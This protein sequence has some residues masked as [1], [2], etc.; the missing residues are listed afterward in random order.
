ML[1]DER[2]WA[3]KYLV[4]GAQFVFACLQSLVACRERGGPLHLRKGS[5]HTASHRKIITMQEA[6]LC[7]ALIKVGSDHGRG[8]VLSSNGR[9]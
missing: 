2:T 6:R 7:L 3:V 4:F 5:G 1:D 9:T 8:T